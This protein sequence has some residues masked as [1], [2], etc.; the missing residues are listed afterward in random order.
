MGACTGAVG[1]AGGEA[2]GEDF[3]VSVTGAGAF[4]EGDGAAALGD[5]AGDLDGEDPGAWA[6]ADPASKARKETNT[7]VE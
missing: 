1:G 7:R 5:A 3:G 2:T 4:T 6:R